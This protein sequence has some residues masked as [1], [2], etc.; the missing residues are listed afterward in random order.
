MVVCGFLSHQSQAAPRTHSNEL[1][2]LLSIRDVREDWDLPMSRGELRP[3]ILDH[4]SHQ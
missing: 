3:I 1:C 2:C 4:S